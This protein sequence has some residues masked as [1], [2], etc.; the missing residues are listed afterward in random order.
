MNSKDQFDPK[1]SELLDQLKE[2]PERDPEIVEKNYKK[3]I[4]EL[5]ALPL[6]QER[7][8]SL[9][10]LL[11]SLGFRKA[12]QQNKENL[13][14]MTKNKSRVAITI[15]VVLVIAVVFLFGGSAATVLASRNAI[16]GDALY[17]LKT[18]YENTRL[19]LTSNDETRVDLHLKYAEQRLAE[20]ESLI[21]K[22]RIDRIEPASEA[23]ENHIK[24]ALDEVKEVAEQDPVRASY[25]MSRI[26][27]ALSR[28]SE[29]LGKIS[30]YIPES[31]MND[32]RDIV[33]DDDMF[34]DD[35]DDMYDD[36]DD[37]MFD[38][39]DDDMYDDDDDDMYDDDDDDDK[40]EED[41]EED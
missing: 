23:F 17:S 7:P 32:I 18:A 35:D 33:G 5:D 25:L 22:G 12:K 37:D 16:P 6:P 34:D 31:I 9:R 29:S 8:S 24:N 4:A 1:I 26:M 41:D 39:D 11:G 13:N 2:T 14:I 21:S 15:G 38:D 3:F 30:D 36:D 28:Y 10:R 27:G 20:I 19:S 40:Y